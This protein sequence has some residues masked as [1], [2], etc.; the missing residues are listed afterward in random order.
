MSEIHSAG[1]SSLPTAS[2]QNNSSCP[3]CGKYFRRKRTHITKSHPA[4][5]R[6]NIVMRNPSSVSPVVQ[7]ASKDDNLSNSSANTNSDVGH[8]LYMKSDQ[9]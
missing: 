7:T 8:L 4:Q 5:H 6:T 9:K 2:S 1:M 3:Y